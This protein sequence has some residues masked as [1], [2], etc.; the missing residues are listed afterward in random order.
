MSAV[1]SG[2]A[3]FCFEKVVRTV[4]CAVGYRLP[5]DPGTPIG[6]SLLWIFRG[7]KRFG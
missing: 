2:I 7:F 6:L 5:G 1:L 3:L 4:P